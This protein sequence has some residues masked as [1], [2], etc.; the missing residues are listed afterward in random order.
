MPTGPISATQRTSLL[1]VDPTN[2]LH[3]VIGW[4]QFDNVHSNFRQAGG[5]FDRRGKDLDVS[6]VLTPGVFRSDPVLG[7][8]EGTSAT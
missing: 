4:R 7:D 1:A 2:P 3:M 8:S 6:R 5:L